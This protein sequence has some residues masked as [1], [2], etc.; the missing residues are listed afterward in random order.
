[1]V[2]CPAHALPR[3]GGIDKR[4][5]FSLVCWR[6][7]RMHEKRLRSYRKETV[8]SEVISYRQ[9]TARESGVESDNKQRRT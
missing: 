9:M 6:Q 4:Q 8:A 3:K 7:V 2:F 1:M 5:Q